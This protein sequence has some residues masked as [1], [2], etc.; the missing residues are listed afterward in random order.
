MADY[1]AWV[2][3]AGDEV[4][5]FK[6]LSLFGLAYELKY[7]AGGLAYRFYLKK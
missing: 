4:L 1:N 6:H 2:F 5:F 7:L 3:S